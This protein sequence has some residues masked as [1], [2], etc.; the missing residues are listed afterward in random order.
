MA[1]MQTCDMQ[2]INV[3]RLRTLI[4]DVLISLEEEPTFVE[5]VAL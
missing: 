2:T 4:F 5:I 1:A 3:T